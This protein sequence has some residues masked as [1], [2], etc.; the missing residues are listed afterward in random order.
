MSNLFSFWQCEV[1]FLYG[2]MLM[3]A[4]MRFEGDV[5]ERMLVAYY[6]Y[7]YDLATFIFLISFYL[8]IILILWC[9]MANVYDLSK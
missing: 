6:R 2:V 9:M 5:R 4:D 3:I 8:N 1:L 7:W